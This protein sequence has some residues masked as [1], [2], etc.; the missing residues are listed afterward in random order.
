VA[1]YSFTVEDFHLLLFAQSPGALTYDFFRFVSGAHE[2][3]ESKSSLSQSECGAAGCVSSSHPPPRFPPRLYWTD[4][5]LL[6]L[7]APTSAT[8]RLTV[9]ALRRYWLN[10]CFIL[11]RK[12][13]YFTH[14][15]GLKVRA[16]KISVFT[17]SGFLRAKV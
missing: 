7:T 1:C 10:E 13:D 17:N 5:A 4:S 6:G 9:G 3:Q 2:Q 15:E 11:T 12:G 16:K 8:R 14:P